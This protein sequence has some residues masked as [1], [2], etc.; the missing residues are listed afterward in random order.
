MLSYNTSPVMAVQPVATRPGAPNS[1]IRLTFAP[2]HKRSLGIA[3]GTVTGA[4]VFALTV[5]HLIFRPGNAFDLRL[6]AQYF[7]K[8]DVSW[9]GASIGLFWGFMTGF[10]SGWFIAFVRNLTIALHA[11]RF[12]TRAELAQTQ[13]FLDH[14]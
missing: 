1:A 11:F 13:D 14:M 5:F 3:L 8:Y 2:V 10:V 9:T 12:R 6:L 4:G 7:Y